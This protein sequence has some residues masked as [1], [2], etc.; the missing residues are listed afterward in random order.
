MADVAGDALFF[1]VEA[2]LG[3]GGTNAF[4]GGD[5]SSGDCTHCDGRRTAPTAADGAGCGVAA[6]AAP[7]FATGV[8]PRAEAASAAVL[9]RDA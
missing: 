3:G 9:E 8:V 4:G 6:T 2:G 5:S 1:D 7:F